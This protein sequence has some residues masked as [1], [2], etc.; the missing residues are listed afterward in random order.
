MKLPSTAAPHPSRPLRWAALS[1]CCAAPLLPAHA[2]SLDTRSQTLSTRRTRCWHEAEPWVSII[3]VK[4]VKTILTA[5]ATKLGAA[6]DPGL[7]VFL[8]AR[9]PDQRDDERDQ[10]GDRVVRQGDRLHRGAAAVAG[11][12]RRR[13]SRRRTGGRQRQAQRADVEAQARLRRCRARTAKRASRMSSRSRS[14][15][16]GRRR[17]GR[18]PTP[19]VKG[20]RRRRRAAAASIPKQRVLGLVADVGGPGLNGV[21]KPKTKVELEERAKFASALLN[22]EKEAKKAALESS[23]CVL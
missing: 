10:G 4:L 13:R 2:E 23:T 20:A 21:V 11:V 22:L 14:S 6:A 9:L 12:A 18:A 16:S 3:L 7:D 17:S 8:A 15:S 19:R 1:A 5:D